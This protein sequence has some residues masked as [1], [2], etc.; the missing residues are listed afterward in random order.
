MITITS[1]PFNDYGR[2]IGSVVLS[3]RTDEVKI[4]ESAYLLCMFVR[5]WVHFRIKM[6]AG[7]R[8]LAGSGEVLRH[9]FA[10]IVTVR[11]RMGTSLPRYQ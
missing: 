8:L 10:C 1:I 5:M 11:V 4:I 9:P 7:T 6:L 3:V 2:R